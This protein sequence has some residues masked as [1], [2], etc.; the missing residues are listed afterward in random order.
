M[1]YQTFS[2]YNQTDLA[3]LFTYP[4][5][6]VPQFIPMV[7]MAIFFITI[8]GTY[9]SQKRLTGRGDFF[10]SFAVA[11]FFTAVIAFVMTLVEN[12]INVQTL[13]IAASV[14][15]IGLILLLTN[16]NKQS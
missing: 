10:A 14:A 5:Q 1:A 3:G 13:V 8:M 2:E 15:L 16:T 4:A 7:L 12:L 11:G 9:F 6:V